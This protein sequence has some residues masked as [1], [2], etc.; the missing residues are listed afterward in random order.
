MEFQVA[1]ELAASG[2]PVIFN[3]VHSAPTAW[4]KKDVLVGPPLTPSPVRVLADANVTFALALPYDSKSSCASKKDYYFL[5][6]LTFP[7]DWHLHNL[8]IEASWAAKDA[9]LSPQ[10][11]VDLVSGKID[12][13]LGLSGRE[14]NRDYV[15]YEGN[16]LEY[17]ANV[18]LAIDGDDGTV[19]SCWPEAD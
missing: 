8:G 5:Y 4:E 16:P 12:A 1:D 14:S 7:A 6:V 3:A 13:I 19:R 9:G 15:I 2:V 10:H 11:A 18:V 17:G